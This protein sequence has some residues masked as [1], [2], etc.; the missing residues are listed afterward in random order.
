LIAYA[1]RGP[2]GKLRASSEGAALPRKPE[3]SEFF[4]TREA[5]PFQNH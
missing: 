4:R 2:F 5:M 3:C 1:L